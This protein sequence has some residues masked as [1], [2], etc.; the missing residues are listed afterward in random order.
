MAIIREFRTLK[1]WEKVSRV[2]IKVG[3]KKSVRGLIF[4]RNYR[5]GAA[6]LVNFFAL[7]LFDKVFLYTVYGN[8]RV[9]GMGSSWFFMDVLYEPYR[10]NLGFAW[11]FV[12][13]FCSSFRPLWWFLG[14]ALNHW[15]RI[16]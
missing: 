14:R 3:A 6:E 13:L 8:L 5:L 15:L 1:G 2:E 12:S 11:G 10:K 7:W 9:R 4:S 16:G